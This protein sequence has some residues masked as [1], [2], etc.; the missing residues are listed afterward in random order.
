M[1]LEQFKVGK[2]ER[3]SS[4]GWY[5]TGRLDKEMV[6]FLCCCF[7]VDLS[8]SHLRAPGL[9]RGWEIRP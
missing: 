6:C 4:G 1:G 3:R 7:T 2:R 5:H 9:F 8:R